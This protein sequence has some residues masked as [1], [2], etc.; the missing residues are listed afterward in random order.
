MG[1]LFRAREYKIMNQ[2]VW[3]TV[4]SKKGAHIG[5]SHYRQLISPTPFC[6]TL[7]SFH[8]GSPHSQNTVTRGAA[9]IGIIAGCPV[10]FP[11]T[12]IVT[13]IGPQPETVTVIGGGHVLFPAIWH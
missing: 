11:P 1:Y 13:N 12:H 8:A 7:F 3:R 5:K 9:V 10:Q 6:S 2:S 4:F